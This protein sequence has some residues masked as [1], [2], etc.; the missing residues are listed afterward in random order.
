MPPERNKRTNNRN[1]KISHITHV[2]LASWLF[3]VVTLMCTS[4]MRLTFCNDS[5]ASPL[6]SPE[7]ANYCV[8]LLSSHLLFSLENFNRK[9][10]D[11][12]ALFIVLLFAIAL[13]YS[14]MDA[15]YF[16]DPISCS[17]K[18]TTLDLKVIQDPAAI[19]F[20]SFAVLLTVYWIIFP[21]AIYPKMLKK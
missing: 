7:I 5:S 20:E 16:C 17:E 10:L 4:I 3:A 6:R 8:V 18:N 12:L 9:Y 2:Y 11:Y 14:L 19:I 1:A 15:G 13:C 21:V